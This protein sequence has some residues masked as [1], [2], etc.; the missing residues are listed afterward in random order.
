MF[1]RDQ[2]AKKVG[3]VLLFSSKG[4]VKFYARIEK[5]SDKKVTV[6]VGGRGKGWFSRGVMEEDEKTI[7]VLH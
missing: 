4:L 1:W 7:G 3:F 2:L 6:W 5:E